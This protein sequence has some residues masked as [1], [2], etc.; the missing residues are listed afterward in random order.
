MIKRKITQFICRLPNSI[1]LESFNTVCY[2]DNHCKF[3]KLHLQKIHIDNPF[4]IVTANYVKY[5]F[6]GNCWWRS[7]YEILFYRKKISSSWTLGYRCLKFNRYFNKSLK[8]TTCFSLY[9]NKRLR[10]TN[11]VERKKNNQQKKVINL[12]RT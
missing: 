7:S 2:N 10:R 12:P 9:I 5:R 4:Q 8:I 6:L 11:W 3:L 1:R